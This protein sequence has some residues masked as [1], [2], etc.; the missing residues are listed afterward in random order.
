MWSM[1]ATQY[2]SSN[3]PV[4]IKPRPQVS[5][6][7]LQWVQLQRC[8]VHLVDAT[9]NPTPEKVKYARTSC[10]ILATGRLHQ[11]DWIIMDKSGNRH[12]YASSAK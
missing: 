8:V 12:Q 1:V 6:S 4:E 3:G 5:F 11:R 9:R 7:T 10:Y 2:F